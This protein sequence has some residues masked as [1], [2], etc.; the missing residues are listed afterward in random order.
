MW[1]WFI[2]AIYANIGDGLWHGPL[3]TKIKNYWIL[4]MDPHGSPMA[5]A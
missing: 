2:Q 1:G 3:T 5:M 4:E